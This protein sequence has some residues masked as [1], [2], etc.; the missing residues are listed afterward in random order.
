MKSK[1]YGSFLCGAA[2]FLFSQAAV[3]D[4]GDS[5]V[6]STQ[7]A[8]SLEFDAGVSVSEQFTDNVF[9]TANDR[10]SDFITVIE[11]WISLALRRQDFRLNLDASAEFGRFADYSSEDFNDYFLGA[12]ARYRINDS[13][14]AFGG[15]DFAWE[16]ENRNS[17][18]DV[19]GVKPTELHDASGFFGIGGK[20]NDKSFRLGV[21]VRDLDYDD[22]RAFDGVT[23]VNVDNDD[24]DRLQTEIGGRL[25]VAKTTNGEVFVQ[26]IYDKREYDEKIDNGGLGFQR[27]SDGFQAAVGYTGTVGEMRGEVLVGVMSQNYDDPRFGTTTTVDLGADLTWPLSAKTQLTGI[28]ER[29][30]EETTLAGA[31]GYVS[32]SAGLRLR[33]SV[34]PNMSVAGYFFLTQNDYQGAARTDI[35]TETGISLRRYLNSRVYLDTDYDFLQR[36][37]DVAGVEYDEH[38]LTLSFGMSLDPRYDAGSVDLAKA[39]GSGFYVGAQVSDSAL[40]TKVDG[41]RGG[42]GNLTADFGDHDLTGGVFAGYRTDFGNLVLGAEAEVDF[43]ESGWTHLANRDFSAKRGNSF[44]VSALTGVRTKND[45]LIYGRFGLVSTE[46][47]STYQQGTNPLVSTS[48]RKLGFLLGVGTEVP[49]G[50]RVSARMEYQ[51]RAYEDYDIGSPLGGGDDDNFANVESV[52]RLGLVYALGGTNRAT[53]EI[54]PTDFSGLYAGVQLGHGSLQSDNVGPRVSGSGVAFTLD[55]TRAGQGFTG[56]LVAGYGHQINNFYVGGEAEFELSTADWNIERS[57]QGR[58]YSAKKLGTIGAGLRL[59]Y[60]VNDSVLLYGRAGVVRSKFNTEYQ[61]GGVSVDQNDNLNGI[62]LG[63]G[64]EFEIGKKTNVRFDYT[65]TDYESHSVNYVAG[66]DQFDTSEQLFRVGLTRKF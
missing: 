35:L 34:A 56:G 64:V 28:V 18:D 12:Q 29:S 3:A 33:H 40:H 45:S 15:L 21:N 39:S 49:L 31:S 19:D 17:P 27:S 6:L 16:H 2:T 61:F 43:G 11:P 4:G 10:R 36:Q 26:G 50:R 48:D 5:V 47:D 54:E 52:A 37:S 57:P 60:V 32:T 38:R 24:R 8:N 13:V 23:F 55:A 58:I 41:P 20:I 1:I 51:V 7:G 65:H 9:L 25:G 22:V 63:G 59:G 14:F 42:G 53:P 44:G 66:V 30:I 62:R 46:F